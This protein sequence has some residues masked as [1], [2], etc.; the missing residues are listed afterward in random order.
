MTKSLLFTILILSSI[1]VVAHS[2]FFHPSIENITL[3]K[4]ALVSLKSRV[5]RTYSNQLQWYSDS[6]YKGKIKANQLEFGVRFA[7]PVDGEVVILLHGFAQTSFAWRDQ[8]A[9]LGAAGYFAIAPTQRGYS[10]KARPS[11][12]EAYKLSELRKDLM[13]I[14]DKLDADSFHLVGHDIGAILAWQLAARYP[15]RIRSLSIFSAPHIDLYNTNVDNSNSCQYQASSYLDLLTS[16]ESEDFLLAD[17]GAKLRALYNDE[18]DNVAIDEYVSL[19]NNKKTLSAA[20]NWY[21]A[22]TQDRHLISEPIG[23]ISVPTLYVWG[24]EDS[25]FCGELADKT[26]SLI[27]SEYNFKKLKNIGHWIPE[28]ASLRVTVDLLFHIWSN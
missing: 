3:D 25:A 16:P 15:S 1:K 19:L 26:D 23:S 24:T 22:N 20:L 12:V 8:L 2:M 17:D 11:D 27:A 28:Q 13:E 21:R 18:I 6:I 9:A 7:G 14:V 5:Q 4:K 10:P